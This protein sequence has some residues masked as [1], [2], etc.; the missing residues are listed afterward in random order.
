M[1]ERK[2]FKDKRATKKHLE[3]PMFMNVMNFFTSVESWTVSETS[4]IS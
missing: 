3:A 4:L 1:L 2:V